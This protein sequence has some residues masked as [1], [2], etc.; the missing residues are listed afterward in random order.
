LSALAAAALRRGGRWGFVLLS[1]DKPPPLW[2]TLSASYL[3]VS[4]SSSFAGVWSKRAV[5]R[6]SDEC[7]LGLLHHEIHELGLVNNLD[8]DLDRTQKNQF[9]LW[10]YLKSWSQSGESCL[11]SGLFLPKIILGYLGEINLFSELVPL[12]NDLVALAHQT[13]P[14]LTSSF[15]R[16]LTKHFLAG[17][18]SAQ[19]L[20]RPHPHSS[21][22]TS[23]A[24][25]RA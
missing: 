20:L 5:E 8:A 22:L 3:K 24:H 9:L 14:S 10:L 4:H 7:L 21:V 25:P 12:R 23:S 2:Q 15:G 18:T 11:A 19:P 6:L 1:F 17:S 16:A 13:R